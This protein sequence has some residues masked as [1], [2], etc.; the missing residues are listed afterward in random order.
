MESAPQSVPIMNSPCRTH[1]GL[2]AS[3][4]KLVIPLAFIALLWTTVRG[5]DLAPNFLILYSK[6]GNEVIHG[7]CNLKDNS[8][9]VV[10]CTFADLTI[11]R[12]QPLD[13]E[14]RLALKLVEYAQQPS[15]SAAADLKADLRGLVEKFKRQL[16]Q[17]EAAHSFGVEVTR[18][19]LEG[20]RKTLDE[21]ENNDSTKIVKEV[22]EGSIPQITDE[23]K[24]KLLND[25]TLG[26]KTKEFWR[27]FIAASSARDPVKL[28]NLTQSK[29][30]R[31]CG[32]QLGTYSIEF[33]QIGKGRW[34]SNEGPQGLCKIVR[35][36]QLDL[37]PSAP[38]LWTLT[39]KNITTG[40]VSNPMC[41]MFANAEQ[42]E[43]VEVYSW[44]YK[45]EFELPCDFIEWFGTGH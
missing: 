42:Q 20:F 7:E 13:E 16:K 27:Q 14:D 41:K 8:A 11:I 22:Q 37:N 19:R 24:N 6:K 5:E 18:A 2:G 32:S 36:Y 10:T 15:S 39:Q 4:L 21:I 3:L 43:P 9:E 17:E 28:T 45:H 33:K 25:P 1:T 29:Q 30:Q 40:D 12:P 38:E 34:L 44:E 31:T 26:P 35:I 23:Q